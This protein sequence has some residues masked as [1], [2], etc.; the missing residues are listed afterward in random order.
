MNH[1]RFTQA[2]ELSRCTQYRHMPIHRKN[3]AIG[4]NTPKTPHGSRAQ[5]DILV[6]SILP[7][8][9]GVRAS[10][11]NVDTRKSLAAC[12]VV[13]Q[14]SMDLSHN[15]IQ[16]VSA[17]KL[18]GSISSPCP[19]HTVEAVEVVGLPEALGFS[20]NLSIQP[21]RLSQ[22]SGLAYCY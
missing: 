15:M 8:N 19:L 11:S 17:P 6:V 18:I 4:P 2:L 5:K 13:S 14:S 20:V 1:I 22:R 7:K 21:P 12:R 10:T 9:T 3:S 16:C